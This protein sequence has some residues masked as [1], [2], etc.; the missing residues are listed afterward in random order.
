MAP[1]SLEGTFLGMLSVAFRVECPSCANART[2]PTEQAKNDPS[3]PAETGLC[4][5]ACTV[6]E[7]MCAGLLEVVSY[8][9]PSCGALIHPAD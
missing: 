4:L 7:C 1:R 2:R 3:L 6:S 9:R 5:F 8:V